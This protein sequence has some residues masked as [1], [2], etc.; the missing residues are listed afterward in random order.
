MEKTVTTRQLIFVLILSVVTLKVLFLP[1][2]LATNIGRDG[3]IM[4]LFLLLVDFLV[5]LML[6]YLMNKFKDK[7]FY[8][9]LCI[10]CGKW[11]AKIIMFLLCLYFLTRCFVRFQTNFIYL[12]ENLYTTLEWYIFAFP[13]LI[14]VI[15]C[16]RQGIKAFA[17]LSE[18]FVPVILFGFCIALIVGIFR[19][20]FTNAL[21]ILENGIAFIK[22]S[23]KYS[24]WFGDYLALI[25]FFGK[26]KM[27]KKFNLKVTLSLLSLIVAVASFYAVF[28]FT[29]GYNTV[30][31][32]NAISDIMQF[33]PS[34]SDI[35]SFDWFLILIWDMA[36][37][38]DLTLNTI[39][40]TE[41]FCKVFNI[42]KNKMIVSI[43]VLVLVIA[44]NILI[45]FNIYLTMKIFRDYIYIFDSIIESLL[46]LALFILAL[47]K[48]RKK[49]EVLVA[50]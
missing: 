16:V 23:S 29:Y 22:S 47:I 41:L 25:L 37:F 31:H 4:L 35:G 6:L 14:C 3:Y 17:R 2:V 24:V 36:L 11:I 39:I 13:I 44:L 20:D 12:S 28:Y 43:I 46:P 45:N 15:F 50:Q 1:N 38:L 27:D 18:V 48:R 40:L 19:A 30:C 42:K 34:V 21:P 32:I 5:L 49:R 8:D 7:T 33:L 26:V 9:V 10:L